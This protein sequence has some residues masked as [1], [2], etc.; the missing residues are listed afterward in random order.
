M[1]AP[2]RRRSP[3]AVG[4]AAQAGRHALA[5]LAGLLLAWAPHTWADGSDEFKTGGPGHALSSPAG[6]DGPRRLKQQ[7]RVT[8]ETNAPPARLG[9]KPAAPKARVFSWESS[10]EGWQGLHLA[11]SRKTRLEGP[12]A[13]A[14]LRLQGT[15]AYRVLHLEELRMSG[16]LGGKLAVDGAAFVTSDDFDDFDGGV[17]LR[18]ARVYARGDCLLVLPVSYQ[19][20]VGYIP[21]EFYIE[22]SY[23]AFKGIPWIGELRAGQYQAPMGL[24]V[25]TGSRDITF[26]EPAAP[27]LALAPGVNA[28]VQMGRAVLDQR[29]TWRFG[30]FA[31]GV[32]DDFGDATE[33]Y[34][35]AIVRFTGLPFYQADSEDPNAT[36]LLHLGLSAN[37]LYS[38]SSS[39]RYRAR[40]ESHLAPH[41]LDTGEIEAD[42]ALILGAEA[43]WVNGPFSA[44]GEFLHSW[45][46]E[47]DGEV[48]GFDGVYVST[49]WFLTGESRRYDRA[50]G[51]FGRVIPKR[52]FDLN[53]GGWGAWEVAARYSL[54]NLNSA[55]ITG[56]RLSMFMFGAN[57]HLHPNVKWRF[58][59]GF[60][61]VTG[62]QPEG[63]INVFETR[64]EIDF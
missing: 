62:R 25:I 46:R 24:D 10:W 4:F 11:V 60:G 30:L 33:D 8:M 20:E 53:H 41:V 64:V 9:T 1:L 34:G 61:R 42:G 2:A 56:G 36:R 6:E 15:N 13:E 39:V 17:E 31:D 29:L 40:P 52:N 27:L 3:G 5:I 45:V 51:M 14:A 23:L 32:G 49:S 35:R 22:E 37:V 21:D 59:Y 7:V 26:M 12:L 43:A 54:V 47:N 58:D 48:P 28:G 63:E 55:R 57:W 18:R 19:L 16:K 44:Q 50:E 38:A